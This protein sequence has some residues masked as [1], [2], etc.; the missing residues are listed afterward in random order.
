MTGHKI[1]LAGF[2]LDKAGRAVV[3]DQRRLDVS[4]RLKQATSKRVRVARRR[5]PR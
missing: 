3:R 4:T 1:K 5:T 2:R